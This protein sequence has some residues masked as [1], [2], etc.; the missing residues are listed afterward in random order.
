MTV[1]DIKLALFFIISITFCGVLIKYVENNC[2]VCI[3]KQTI[4]E[5]NS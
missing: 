4:C 1:K 5:N 2:K 3:N